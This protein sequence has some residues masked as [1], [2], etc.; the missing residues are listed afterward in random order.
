MRSSRIVLGVFALLALVTS[1]RADPP[2]NWEPNEDQ[3]AILS[4]R[5][6][7]LLEL[8]DMVQQGGGAGCTCPAFY[9]CPTEWP[10]PHGPY[11]DDPDGIYSKCWEQYMEH[12][13]SITLV[14]FECVAS[15]TPHPTSPNCYAQSCINNCNWSNLLRLLWGELQYSCCIEPTQPGCEEYTEARGAPV[16]FMS[17]N[18]CAS[19]VKPYA[20]YEEPTCSPCPDGYIPMP[21]LPQVPPAAPGDDLSTT[22]YLDFSLAW[23]NAMDAYYTCVDGFRHP[24]CPN[25]LKDGWD[26]V[27]CQTAFTQTILELRENY[28]SCLNN[29]GEGGNRIAWVSDLPTW[30]RLRVAAVLN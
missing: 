25:C 29:P 14:F 5:N 11:E 9:N 8:Y 21:D 7:A 6:P 28:A 4:A 1:V 23:L 16:P 10:T 27:G 13:A 22:C 15:C 18:V 3:R 30:L 12:H 19:M 17:I 26:E 2:P 20:Y 24:E